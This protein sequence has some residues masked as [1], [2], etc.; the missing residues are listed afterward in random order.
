MAEIWNNKN[1]GGIV[2]IMITLLIMTS[3]LIVSASYFNNKQI[4]SASSQCYDK[5]G[6]VQVEIHNTWTNDFSFQCK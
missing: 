3:I 5:G 1:T 2:L 4:Q 6:E